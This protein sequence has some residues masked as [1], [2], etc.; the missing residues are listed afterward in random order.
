MLVRNN[1]P[2]S[3]FANFLCLCVTS[4]SWTRTLDLRM[5]S[6]VAKQLNLILNFMA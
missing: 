6:Q 1:R 5:M 4:N 3:L 2:A